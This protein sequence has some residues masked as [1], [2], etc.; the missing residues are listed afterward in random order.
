MKP[1]RVLIV[2][3]SLTV[4]VFLTSLF[5]GAGGIEV[6]GCAPSV[7]VA[8]EMI[9]AF[10][11]DVLTLDVL[12]PGASGLELLETVMRRRPMPVIMVSSLT[13]AG[14]ATAVEALRLGAIG[15]LGKPVAGA[16]G[17]LQAMAA[18][19]IAMVREAATANVSALG[20]PA[21]PPVAAP[22][23]WNGRVVVIGAAMGGVEA[24][25]RVLGGFPQNCPPTAIVQHMPS[26]FTGHL[27]KRLDQACAP[28]VIEAGQGMRLEQGTIHIAPGGD[29]H[30]EI[31]GWPGGMLR[32]EPGVLVNGHSPS[33]DTLFHSAA[34]NA[35][36]AA[37][38][39]LLTGMGDDG[40]AGLRAI[41]RA[42]GTTFAQL[43]AGCVVPDM[44]RAAKDMGVVQHE[45]EPEELGAAILERTAFA[46]AIAA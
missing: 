42:G 27:A 45:L 46:P 3:D 44:V 29:H 26:A 39:V 17:S 28:R 33:I 10:A 34:A 16:G 32:A 23:D 22:Y 1:I 20:E 8:H 5:E 2:D 11:P 35:G 25:F 43:E 9:E 36:P 14:A 19:L 21:P 18:E 41:R 4:R 6:V 37:I 7:A 30:L 24:L 38:G 13:Q 31:G 40:A 12:M 15:C